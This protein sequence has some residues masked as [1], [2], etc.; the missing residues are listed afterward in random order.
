MVQREAAGAA[1]GPPS[2][3][4]RSVD[5]PP[6]SGTNAEPSRPAGRGV[7]A[8]KPAWMAER[9]AAGGPLS[10]PPRSTDG[11]A[12]KPAP[13]PA[14][15]AKPPPPLYFDVMRGDDSL[16]RLDLSGAPALNDAAVGLSAVGRF[17]DPSERTRNARNTPVQG[18][19]ALVR[20]LQGYFRVFLHG[21]EN[22]GG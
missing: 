6:D 20:E 16:G 7:A 11:P 4:A 21:L 22:A 19:L 12:L 3:P 17:G 5:E 13:A 18:V 15:F 2:A 14:P 8:T 1:V 9:E 10:A